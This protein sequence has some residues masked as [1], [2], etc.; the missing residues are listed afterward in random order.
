MSQLSADGNTRLHRSSCSA[1]E[2]DSLPG[3][4][5][6][7]RLMP[8]IF[9]APAVLQHRDVCRAVMLTTQHLADGGLT[10]GDDMDSQEITVDLVT[11]GKCN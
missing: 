10:S 11:E 5:V 7:H 9:C 3:S 1:N 2:Q 4:A 8:T 6:M